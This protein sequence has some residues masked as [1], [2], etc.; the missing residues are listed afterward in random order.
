MQGSYQL[1]TGSLPSSNLRNSSRFDAWI[2]PGTLQRR[3]IIAVWF[4]PLAFWA[5]KKRELQQNWHT[6]RRVRQTAYP[7]RSRNP[8]QRWHLT[9]CLTAA[10]T[11]AGCGD[12]GDQSS[13][14]TQYSGDFNAMTLTQKALSPVL[15][16]WLHDSG[17]ASTSHPHEKA[18]ES[19][20]NSF[21]TSV[22]IWFTTIVLCRQI[23]HNR[24]LCW[25]GQGDEKH[26]HFSMN[27]FYMYLPLS[28]ADSCLSD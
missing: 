10:A 14:F 20:Q 3:Q 22:S 24:L 1:P 9:D 16:N 21:P 4:R 27:H 25:N 23:L 11:E 8:Q 6:D 28:C 26:P 7:Q 12:R 18:T 15:A 19:R 13:P 5:E 2:L 17:Y